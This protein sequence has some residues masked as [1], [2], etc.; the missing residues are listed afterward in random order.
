M[1]KQYNI[2]VRAGGG[3]VFGG[4]GQGARPRPATGGPARRA[5]RA[6]DRPA[7]PSPPPPL[8]P[9]H[10]LHEGGVERAGCREGVRGQR[11]WG[12][13][14]EEGEGD[15]RRRPDWLTPCPAPPPVPLASPPSF[16]RTCPSSPTS[17]TVSVKDSDGW[18]TVERRTPPA[19]GPPPSRRAPRAGAPP[20]R[21][22][23][24]ARP[25]AGS[26]G[27][28]SDGGE[29]GLGRGS[30]GRRRRKQEGG[31]EHKGTTALTPP[32]SPGKSTLTDSLV[33]AA[34]IIAMEAAGDQRLTDTRQ[35][36]QDR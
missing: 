5:N 20:S 16:H 29:G 26:W 12:G 24:P 27:R 3:G 30:E 25:A 10:P 13:A 36:E 14:G 19:P 33:A 9:R 28:A 22:G 31:G 6:P 17:T 35:D 21:P 4:G 32:P 15:R 18:T 34:G 1:D 23:P 7:P 2:R 8:P 11:A